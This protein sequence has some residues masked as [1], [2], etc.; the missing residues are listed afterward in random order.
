VLDV[1]GATKWADVG[2]LHPGRP[3]GDS[4][5]GGRAYL[6][7]GQIC[8]SRT[9]I[10]HHSGCQPPANVGVG[11]GAP[12][13]P[14]PR[15]AMSTTWGG[16]ACVGCRAADP[17]GN[18]KPIALSLKLGGVALER[19]AFLRLHLRRDRDRFV[20]RQSRLMRTGF[21]IDQSRFETWSRGLSA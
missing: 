10:Q 15:C 4:I 19:R 8:Y 17:A 14:G 13:G 21:R 12:K 20:R 11:I 2:V 6:S 9:W 16:N 3:E 1:Q 5:V 18:A 7:D